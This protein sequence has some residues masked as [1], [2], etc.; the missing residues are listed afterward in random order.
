MPVL[1]PPSFYLLLLLLNPIN[2]V[3]ILKRHLNFMVCI[4]FPNQISVFL[5]LLII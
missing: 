3:C 4:A 2:S 5:Y 1:A